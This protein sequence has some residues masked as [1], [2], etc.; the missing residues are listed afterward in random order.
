[1]MG[2]HIWLSQFKNARAW[3]TVVICK[4]AEA[5]RV[6]TSSKYT[7]PVGHMYHVW[8]TWKKLRTYEG[9]GMR[10]WWRL[11]LALQWQRYQM[12]INSLFFFFEK[13]LSHKCRNRRDR[14]VHRAVLN[15]VCVIWLGFQP[16]LLCNPS[17]LSV[18]KYMICIAGWKR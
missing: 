1:M 5:T 4:D 17:W 9:W 18:S 6:F 14:E 10:V 8:S 3:S 16:L 13:L 11:L 2:N 7:F 12:N 15:T